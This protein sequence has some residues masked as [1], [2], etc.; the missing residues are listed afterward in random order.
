MKLLEGQA[1]LVTG[2]DSGI[3]A[4]TCRAL[5]ASGARVAIN[6]LADSTAADAMCKEVAASGGEAIAVQGD[7][8]SEEEVGR[9]FER[10][11]A[12][13]GRI[14]ILV[15]NAGIQAD[16]AVTQMTLAAWRRVLDVNL[17]GQF[18]CA[19]EA[20]RRF[21][22]QPATPL[23]RAAGKI[24]CMS[25]VHEVIPWAGHVNYAASKGGVHL[26]M[27]TLAQEVARKR[28]RVNAIAPGAIA[29]AINRS[30]WDTPEARAKLVT[31]I[32]YGRVG[33]PADVAR[34]VLWLASDDSD[35]VTGTTL[36][37]DGGMSLYPGFVD[38]G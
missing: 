35:Y 4:G 9:M 34:A 18:L 27:K 26:M 5:A 23:S 3:G 1:A 11:V 30:A 22:A 32:P 20:I 16:A 33:E 24:I 21:L 17:T 13:F 8:S 14:D 7:V 15:A 38:N 2:G 29:T 19:R 10:C 36:F 6:Y 37:V 12:A 25:S 28:I 31:L